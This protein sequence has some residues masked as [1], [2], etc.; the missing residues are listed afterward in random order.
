MRGRRAAPEGHLHAQRG[1]RRLH[2]HGI[3]LQDHRVRA[4]HVQRGG[5]LPEV[6]RLHWEEFV[7]FLKT[8][9]ERFGKILMITDGAPQHRSKLVREEIRLL[10]GLELEFFPPG[11]PGLNAIE[12]L[13]RQM[14]H[15]V[16][17][18]PY[19]RFSPFTQTRVCMAMQV[20]TP[21]LMQ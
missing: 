4:D 2:V 16:L 12:G 1:P 8:A 15:V 7:E 18:M 20:F 9:C 3:A 10:G 19:V 13:W 21:D 17:D 6:R 14:K 5:F 11:C